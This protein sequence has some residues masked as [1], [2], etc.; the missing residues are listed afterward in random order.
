MLTKHSGH[1]FI[2]SV[3]TCT[4][5][6]YTK[7]MPECRH[8]GEYLKINK[9]CSFQRTWPFHAMEFPSGMW[10]NIF[11]MRSLSHVCTRTH[12][13]SYKYQINILDTCLNLAMAADYRL[14]HD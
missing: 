4:C 7:K 1:I 12:P 8:R 14:Q 10:K 5:N 3:S 2:L 13:A 11:F 6:I 9:L